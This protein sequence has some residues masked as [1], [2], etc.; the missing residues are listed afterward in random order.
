MVQFFD[1]QG[2]K[3]NT[4]NMTKTQNTYSSLNDMGEKSDKRDAIITEA[5]D[6]FNRHGYHDTRLEDIASR[7]GKSK[8]TI[9]Y[10]FKSKDVLL[11]EVNARSAEEFNRDISKAN[12]APNG[13]ERILHLIRS[14]AEAHSERLSGRY[15][16]KP[17]L[18]DLRTITHNADPIMMERFQ[19]QVEQIGL[20]LREGAIDQTVRV[21]SAEA[22]T[23]CLMNIMFWLPKWLAQIPNAHHG[24]AIDGLIDILRYGITTN[25]IELKPATAY[26]PR[27]QGYAE[28]FNR[29]VKNKLK[30]DAFFRAGTRHLNHSGYR[31]LSLNDIASELGVTRGAFY[32]YIAD[33]DALL[34]SCFDRT[35]DHLEKALENAQARVTT[36]KIDQLFIAFDGLFQGHITDFDPLLNMKLIPF[37]KPA[38]RAAIKARL[39]RVSAGFS[40]V[41]AEAM[42]DGSARSIEMM[43][44]DQILLGALFSAN[45]WRLSA[46]ALKE[47]WQMQDKGTSVAMAYFEPIFSGLS[48]KKA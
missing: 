43:A 12:L 18:T 5:V 23:F 29:E 9:S 41:I 26:M 44:A 25:N 11:V 13:L 35:C 3:C 33:K 24:A 19:E 40:E 16:L 31:N 7:L 21:L 47:K 17:I 8:A 2:H 32:Y 28:I 37:L 1:F 22:S 36:Q 10:H 27:N 34:E 39:R 42:G 38:K 15:K 6:L 46:T 30:R 14:Q 20:F 4:T 45:Q 48:A